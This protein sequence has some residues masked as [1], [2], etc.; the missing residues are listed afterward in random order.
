MKALQI[1]QTRHIPKVILDAGNNI[2]E[3]S[4]R[5]LSQDALNFYKPVFDWL[6]TYAQSPNPETSFVINF[7]YFNTVSS[8]IILELLCKLEEISKKNSNVSILWCFDYSDMLYIGKEFSELVSIPF[9]FKNVEE[10]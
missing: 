5:S 4:G 8:K 1:E 6:D 3:L 7:E 2:F 10:K 9:K